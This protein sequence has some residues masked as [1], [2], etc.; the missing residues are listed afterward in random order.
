VGA[1]EVDKRGEHKSRQLISEMREP[2]EQG[3][4]SSYQRRESLESREKT[5]HISDEKA[6]TTLEAGTEKEVGG[7]TKSRQQ[8]R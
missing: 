6:K 2:R 1:R 5:A 3:A 8:E 4:D 7:G